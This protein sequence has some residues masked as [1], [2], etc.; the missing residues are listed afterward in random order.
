MKRL[1]N[2][3][4]ILLMTLMA[5]VPLTSKAAED[6][7]TVPL[8]ESNSGPDE[9]P[10]PHQKGERM[11]ARPVMLL[12]TPTGI[13]S[14]LNPAD[15]V[16]YELWDEADCCVVSVADETSFIEAVYSLEGSYILRLR[17]A[18]TVF[19]GYLDL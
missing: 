9:D 3:P 11:P 16:A 1:L 2:L 19:I 13:Q 7:Y 6:S 15:I 14:S 10:D 5:I 17:T 4:V 18:E 8:Q 12:I